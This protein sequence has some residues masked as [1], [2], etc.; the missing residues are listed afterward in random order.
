MLGGSIA[1]K[2]QVA[3]NS[4]KSQ[5]D[6][7][8]QQVRNAESKEKESEEKLTVIEGKIAST[9]NVALQLQTSE[10]H[11]K[12]ALKIMENKLSEYERE[13]KEFKKRAEEAKKKITVCENDL[14]QSR[15]ERDKVLSESKEKQAK[16][17][18]E[19]E[20]LKAKCIDI[21]TERDI[22]MK[23]A[24]EAERE[25][26]EHKRDMGLSPPASLDPSESP[27]VPFKPFPPPASSSKVVMTV[28][29]GT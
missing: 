26:K 29:I 13:R 21:S 16:C 8:Q 4:L 24:M 27:S 2:A 5:L 1:Q 6:K 11:K 19:I 20:V 10:R 7:A 3:I 17:Y 12:E 9:N 23:H 22:H 14:K 18:E 15:N 28:S 25:L